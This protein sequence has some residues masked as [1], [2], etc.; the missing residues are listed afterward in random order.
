[1]DL[2]KILAELKEEKLL[3]EESIIA[4]ERVSMGRGGAVV[5][6]RSG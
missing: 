5:G 3:I 1:M 2:N 4:L 6:R